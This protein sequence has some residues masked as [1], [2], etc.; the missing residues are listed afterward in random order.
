MSIAM[1]TPEERIK[2]A[3]E[4][5]RQT[6]AAADAKAQAEQAARE[7]TL[8]H[9]WQRA[10]AIGQKCRA[11]ARELADAGRV[12]VHIL[13]ERRR[14]REDM[15]PAFLLTIGRP[16]KGMR[17]IR[18]IPQADGQWTIRVFDGDTASHPIADDATFEHAMDEILEPLVTEAAV[19]VAKGE[20]PPGEFR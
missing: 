10:E 14:D 4:A 7:A 15:E 8:K 19:A 12:R 2:K 17:G 9:L 13:L 1:S 16:A 18:A 5:A 3:V 6:K 20:E 11:R